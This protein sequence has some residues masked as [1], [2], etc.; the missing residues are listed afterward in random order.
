MGGGGW[1]GVSGL[2]V[3]DFGCGALFEVGG[4]VLVTCLCV[5]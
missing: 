3:L 1:F 2:G 4:L 5:G